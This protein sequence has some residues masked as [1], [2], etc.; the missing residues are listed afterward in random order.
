[1]STFLTIFNNVMTRL[2]EDTV[3]SFDSEN[4]YENM[5]RL[6]INDAKRQVE[7]AHNWS[8]LRTKTAIATE[9]G[10]QSYVVDT[11]GLDEPI[12]VYDDIGNELGKYGSTFKIITSGASEGSGRPSAYSFDTPQST[13]TVIKFHPIVFYY[14]I[15][16]F[17]TK[18]HFTFFSTLLRHLLLLL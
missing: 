5:V 17:L 11:N 8:F 16:S 2:R 7:M 6:A 1:M 4:A 15:F 13:D 18:I 3:V 10:V 14:S 12:A 9:A